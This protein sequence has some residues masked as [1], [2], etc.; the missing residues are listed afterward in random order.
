MSDSYKN[1]LSHLTP[2]H[3][4]FQLDRP[5]ANR[6]KFEDLVNWIDSNLD[7]NIKLTDLIEQSGLSLYEL[8]QQFMLQVKMSPLQFVKELRKYKQAVALAEEQQVDNTYALFDPQKIKG[9]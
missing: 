1:L 4:G 7:S 2:S 5:A 8:T 3:T 9:L 6:Q